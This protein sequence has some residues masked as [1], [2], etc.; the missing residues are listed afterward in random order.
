FRLTRGP[1][2]HVTARTAQ[3]RITIDGE[4]RTSWSEIVPAG[5]TV[6]IRVDSVQLLAGQRTRASFVRWSDGGP[7]N[8]ELVGIGGRPDTLHADFLVTHRLDVRATEGGAVTSSIP[9]SIGALGTF[10]TT[11]VV[12]R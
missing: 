6:R 11:G 4:T 2:T 5:D 7:R 1:A 8:R 3:A 9:G 12:A 10:V